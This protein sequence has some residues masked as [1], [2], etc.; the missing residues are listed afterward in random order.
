MWMLINVEKQEDI[1]INEKI[2]INV[3]E[4]LFHLT[5]QTMFQFG[6]QM[7]DCIKFEGKG[8]EVHPAR[9]D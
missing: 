9:I 1:G 5:D 3:C 4:R 6:Y 8:I 2:R 7:L